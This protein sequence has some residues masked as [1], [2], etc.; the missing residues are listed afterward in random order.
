MTA[1]QVRSINCLGRLMCTCINSVRVPHRSTVVFR[2]LALLRFDK[3]YIIFAIC[4]DTIYIYISRCIIS[5]FANL[6]RIQW[7]VILFSFFKKEKLNSTDTELPMK[8]HGKQL[9]LE[10]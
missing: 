1:I 9:S 7:L 3:I 5:R 10:Y 4:I 2:R 6:E 8:I